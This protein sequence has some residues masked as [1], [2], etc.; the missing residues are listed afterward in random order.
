[1]RAL[2][3]NP[4]VRTDGKMAEAKVKTAKSRATDTL[5][6]KQLALLVR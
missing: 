1:M 6:P 3:F 2:L 4:L 5:S